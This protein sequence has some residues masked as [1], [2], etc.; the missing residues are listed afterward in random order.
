M[1]HWKWTEEEAELLVAWVSKQKGMKKNLWMLH[2]KYN[3]REKSSIDQE[4]YH[5]G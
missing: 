5:V 2:W 1:L 3:S 4:K